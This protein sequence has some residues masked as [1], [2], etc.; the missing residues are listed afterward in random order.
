MSTDEPHQ[1]PAVDPCDDDLG[2][3]VVMYAEH[4]VMLG[5]FTALS[6]E[7]N[8]IQ[9]ELAMLKAELGSAECP[10]ITPTVAPLSARKDDL[11][12]R[13]MTVVQASDAETDVYLNE[14]LPSLHTLLDRIRRR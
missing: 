6:A 2:A 11:L 1:S 7:T 3:L 12:D 4:V 13:L 5:R 14:M 8:R 9:R 10:V